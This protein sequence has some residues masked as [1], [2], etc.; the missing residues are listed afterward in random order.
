MAGVELV[1]V[2]GVVGEGVE[3]R[4]EEVLGVEGHGGGVGEGDGGGG[5][6]KGGTETVED[7]GNG[8]AKE[9]EVGAVGLE[10]GGAQE[11][12]GAGQGELVGETEV[13]VEF[14]LEGAAVG[15]VVVGAEG[16]VEGVGEVGVGLE[17]G[18][19]VGEAEEAEEL[20]A[21]RE[22]LVDRGGGVGHSLGGFEH[23]DEEF[24]EAEGVGAPVGA[25]RLDVSC[26]DTQH[27]L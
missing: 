19:G 5:P 12:G 17:G 7:V 20:F 26:Q 3:E 23:V 14:A 24:G 18:T 21:E 22:A 16:D 2:E 10:E 13:G 15:F 8:L 25:L 11:V 9:G 6:G 1:V 27:G 4:G